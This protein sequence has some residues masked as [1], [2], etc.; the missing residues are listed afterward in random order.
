M[1]MLGTLRCPQCKQRLMYKSGDAML[2]RTRGPLVFAD[3]GQCSA[4]CYYCK[5]DVNLPVRRV[6]SEAPAAPVEKFV[7]RK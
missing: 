2:L 4:R 7:I 3:N 6:P 5:S 1:V